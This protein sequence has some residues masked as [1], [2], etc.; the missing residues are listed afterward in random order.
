LPDRGAKT[1]KDQIHY[2]YG[3]TLAESAFA[4]GLGG[5]KT[6]SLLNVPYGAFKGG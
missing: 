3:K 6:L 5:A 2:R 4:A 1:M